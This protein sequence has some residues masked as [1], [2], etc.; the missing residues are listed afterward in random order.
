MRVGLVSDT[1]GFHDPRLDQLFAGCDLI[2]HA[3]DIVRPEVLEALGRL[4]PVTAVRGNNDVGP[5][6]EH[7]PELV[8]VE[9]GEVRAVLV[10]Q[11]GGRAR[12]LAPVRRALVASGARL[13]IYG[14]SHQP[15]A[16][17]EQGTAFVNPGSAGPRRFSLPRAAGLLDIARTRAEVRLFDLGLPRLPLLQAPLAFDV[18]AAPARAT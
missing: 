11:I 12:L 13:L 16:V 7:L 6:F 8:E 17:V 5:A 3:G 2:L 10:H 9:L 18:A 14:H 4:A 15:S 1:H